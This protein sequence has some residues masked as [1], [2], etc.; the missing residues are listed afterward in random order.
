MA[1]TSSC[2]KCQ[3]QV[4]VPEGTCPDAVVQCPICSG[5]Y[6]LREILAAAPPALI[7]VHPGSTAA[8][9]QSAA[10]A[11]FGPLGEVAAVAVAVPSSESSEVGIF[12]AHRVEPSLH[13]AEPLL[14][15]G[16]EVQLVTPDDGQAKPFG[17]D[18]GE[19]VAEA[20][21]FEASPTATQESTQES[22]QPIETLVEPFG[23]PLAAP[24]SEE[25]HELAA[26]PVE[27]GA[28]WGGAW[29]GF[30]DEAE[31]A[32]DGAIGLAEPD[33]DEGL[34]HV[35][36]A[37]ITGKA[38]P[39][40]A[41]AAVPGEAAVAVEPPKKKRRK[42]EANPLVR[43]VGVIFF[44]LLAFPC[45]YGIAIWVDHKNDRFHLFYHDDKPT[46]NNTQKPAANTNPTPANTNRPAPDAGKTAQTAA[47][48]NSQPGNKPATPEVAM[49]EPAK[50][51]PKPA[52]PATPKTSKEP[53][54]SGESTDTKPAV[55][56]NTPAPSK[57]ETPAKPEADPFGPAPVVTPVNEKPKTDTKTAVPAPSKTETPAK[58]DADPFG[59]SPVVTPVNEKPKPDTKP[60]VPAPSKTETPAKPE[61]P[62]PGAN[63]AT[64]TPDLKPD[65]LPAI[66]PEPK[67]VKPDVKPEVKPAAG[68]GPLQ[69]PSF[70]AFVLDA[71][72]KAVSGGATVD[73]KSYADWCKLA[74]VVTYVKDGA[75][76]QKQALRTLTEKVAS[77]PQAESAIAAAAKKLLDDRVT[78]GGIVL[79]GTVTGLATK[80]GLCGTAIRIEGMS[81]PVMIFSAHPLDVK[82]TQKVIVLGALVADPAKNLPGY[83]GKQAVVVWSDFAAA[84]Q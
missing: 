44:G 29:G 34:E 73:A 7:V 50:E 45:A 28:P 60:A 16:D 83:P 82:D 1:F 22:D 78:E 69:A 12:A 36:F 27:G 79:A 14:F 58:P 49:N 77:S 66:G 17:S 68:V 47:T 63:P 65:T 21:L 23:E 15:E 5:E 30:K 81:K 56:P 55:E 8:T 39:G 84:L 35:D 41:P 37:A 80:N 67:P 33:Q 42:R 51:S 46:A 61:K 64:K 43:I 75:D 72:L 25:A 74:K 3:K 53:N 57:T 62:E 4:L 2:P 13:D 32:E 9:T 20:A 40:S 71:S 70:P 54:P 10:A 76:S 19:H 11:A 59:P 24:L 48:D 31:H 52:A 18:D 26:E 6:L 38:E